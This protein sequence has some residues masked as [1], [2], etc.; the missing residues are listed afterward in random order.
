MKIVFHKGYTARLPG[1]VFRPDKFEAA[2]LLLLREGAVKRADVLEPEPPSRAD[3]LLAHTAA[4]TDKNLG[5]RFTPADSR[6]AELEITPEVARAHLLNVGGTLLAA[7]LALRQGVGVNCGGGSHHAYPGHGEGFCLL[8]DIAVALRRLLAEKRIKRAFIADLDAHQGNGTA[9]IFRKDPRVFTFSM[10][11][12]AAYPERKERGSLDIE[13]APGTGDAAYLAALGRELPLALERFRPDFLLYV[14]GADV[15]KGDLIGGLALTR[16][17][18]RRRDALVL[19]ECRRRHLPAAVV[20]SGGYARR[21]SDTVR[22][23]A[24]TVKA[25]LA[26]ASLKA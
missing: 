6:R 2:L 4:W 15:Y 22:I 16:A 8:N 26:S 7:R 1:H 20:L 25:A 9:A 5:F 3:L 12:G 10:H 18:I 14:A 11:N 24:D 13:L 17:G 19:A 21:F 23:H